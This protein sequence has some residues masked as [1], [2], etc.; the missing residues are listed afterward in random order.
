MIVVAG[1][2]EV[3]PDNRDAFVAESQ[4]AVRMA[5]ATDGC[6]DFAVSPDLVDPARVNILERWVSVEALAAFR[7][8]GPDDGSAQ[9]I[10]A[11]HVE[12]FTVNDA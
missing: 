11:F 2:L 7:G 9:Q 3:D 4:V 5:R 6:L 1:H 10:R 12:D 8:D